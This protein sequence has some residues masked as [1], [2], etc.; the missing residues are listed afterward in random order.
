MR[1][2]IKIMVIAVLLAYGIA[3]ALAYADTPQK[4]ITQKASEDIKAVIEKQYFKKKP[5]V[6]AFKEEFGVKEDESFDSSGL[7]DGIPYYMINDGTNITFGGYLFEILVQGKPTG[8]I[9]T[10][11]DKNG[12]WKIFDISTDA[13]LS[14]DLSKAKKFLKGNEQAILFYD[15]VRFVYGL[16]TFSGKGEDTFIPLRKHSM[17]AFEAGTELPY[18]DVAEQAKVRYNLKG[19]YDSNGFLLSG[20]VGDSQTEAFPHTAS[21]MPYYVIGATGLC[22]LAILTVLYLRKRSTML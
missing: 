22:A 10:T 18:K 7:S 14:S 4:D 12:G 17:Y 13:N 3:P 16:K 15:D 19:Q 2:I 11:D 5:V 1:Y 9:R 20:G 6:E 21:R 8:L